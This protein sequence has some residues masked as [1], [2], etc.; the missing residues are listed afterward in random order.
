MSKVEI[1]KPIITEVVIKPMTEEEIN[2]SINKLLE[3]Y[4]KTLNVLSRN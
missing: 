3:K 1:E 2:N 4:G